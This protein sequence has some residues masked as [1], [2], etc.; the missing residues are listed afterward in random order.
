MNK[1][2]LVAEMREVVKKRLYAVDTVEQYKN[3][4]NISC[5]ELSRLGILPSL[6][7]VI[8][9]YKE[10]EMFLEKT[11]LTF[12]LLA[13]FLYKDLKIILQLKSYAKNV[14]LKIGLTNN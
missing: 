7:D 8:E 6:D 3:V 9:N 1:K 14:A 10:C 12:G 13:T 5:N 2:E 4:I 11:S